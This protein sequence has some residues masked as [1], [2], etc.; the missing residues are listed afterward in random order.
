MG[1]CPT[2]GEHNR[3]DAQYCAACGNAL[4]AGRRGREERKVVTILF[5]DLV[6]FTSRFDLADPEDVQETLARYHARVRREIERFGGTVEKFIGDAVMAVYGA[7]VAHEDDAQRAVFSALRIPPAIEELNETN[8]D[9]PLAVRIGIET[10]VAVVAVGPERSPQ[11]IAIGDVVNTASR[12][13]GVAPIGGVLVGE[14]TYRL[15]RDL[16]DL[17]SLEPVK[18]KGKAEALPVW[19]AKAARSR[20]GVEI[21]RAPSTPF[22]GRADELELLKHTFARAVRESSVQLVTLLGE[23]GV[24]KSRMIREL[25]TYIDDQPDVVTW[26]QGRCLPYGEGVTFWALGQLVKAQAGILGSDDARVAGD[27]LSACVAGLVDEPGEQEWL[28]ARLAPLVGLSYTKGAA[29]DQPESFSAWR[30]FLEAIASVRPLVIAIEDLHWAQPSMIEFLEHVLEWSTG[31]PMLILCS[32]RPEILQ[33]DPGWGGGMRDSII[34]SLTPLSDEETD[35]LL[36][37][38]LAPGTPSEV[39]ELIAERA[40]GNPL[41]AE[42]FARMLDERSELAGEEADAVGLPSIPAPESLQALIAARLDTLAV[43]EKS[44]VQDASVIGK[45]F[46]LSAVAAIGGRD[47]ETARVGVRDLARRELVRPSRLTSVQGD[48]EY[49]FSHALIRDVA[50]HQIPRLARVD[51]HVAAAGWIERLAAERLS[52]QVELLVHH[53]GQALELSRSAGSDAV[54]DLEVST[55]EALLIAGE[56]AMGFD[57]A[58]AVECFDE[59]IA[60]L[61]E[62]D[63]ERAHAIYLRAEAVQDWGRYEEAERGYRDAIAAFRELGDRVSEGACLTKLSAV[64]S[65]RGELAESRARLAEAVQMLEA[66]PP[67]V[68]LATCFTS[69]ASAHIL[70]GS[71]EEAI[72]L[73]DRALELA[74][75][76]DV[77]SLDSRAL[78]YRGIARCFLGDQAGLDDLQ[79]AQVKAESRGSSR[80]HALALLVR[81]EVEWAIEGPTVALA[82]VRAGR[83][84]A[85]HRGLLDMA[86][87]C[88]ALSLGQLFDVGAWDE[89]LLVADEVVRRSREAGA[90]YAAMLA[91][92][93]ITQ[94]LA[95]RGRVREASE[96]AAGLIARAKEI[97]DAQVL[98]PAS[99]AAALAA[100][101]DG[102]TTD[103]NRIVREL[104]EETNV[105]IDWYREDFLVDLVRICI[106]SGDLPLARRMIERARVTA[107]RHDLSLLSSRAALDEAQ[108]HLAEAASGYEQAV[109]GWDLYGHHLETGMALLGAGRCLAGLDDARSAD[110]RARADEIFEGLGARPIEWSR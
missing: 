5:C 44:L 99:L 11:G 55:R 21:P 94:V 58:R 96:S 28:Q 31:F 86:L 110:R 13:Q 51:K 104:D 17:E 68:E 108:G 90:D 43:E 77:A 87:W 39:R 26:R 16:F 20:F 57:V 33:I 25:F 34:V 72:G 47:L 91:Q 8:R 59:V 46:W 60:L 100:I 93:W 45:V 30:R 38:V 83:D 35:Q 85:E 19:V 81:A 37:N 102:R 56:A 97:G 101:K 79:Q 65:D 18:V 69:L 88:D 23:P 80:E 105:S 76:F 32:A 62:G 36:R 74:T 103:A 1:V 4:Q 89:L 40:G 75:R 49:S 12:L 106:A 66:E 15:T 48:T 6:E 67:G 10:G 92:P 71:F 41:F 3:E 2:C 52:D 64:L 27:K 54:G 78:S 73:C 53:Y 82:T 98:V 14:G 29:V 84:L 7:P 107:R 70:S 22:V 24:G 109:E 9:L 63:P 42:E 61:P 95:W 50:Y